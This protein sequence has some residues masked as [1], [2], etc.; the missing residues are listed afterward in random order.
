VLSGPIVIVD[1]HRMLAQSLGYALSAHGVSV[2][3]PALAEQAR[4]LGDIERLAPC[5]VLLDLDLGDAVGDGAGL[6]G[7][8]AAAGMR[9]LILSGTTQRTRF[10]AA[11]EAGAV[12]YV[13]KGCAFDVLLDTVL[14]AARG[15]DVLPAAD[16]HELATTL[17]T[18]RRAERR[19]LA[20][21]ERLT[22]REAEVLVELAAGNCVA[23][24]AEQSFVSVPTVRTQVRQV[25]AKLDVSS[26]LEAV[27]LAR[28]SGWLDRQPQTV[29]VS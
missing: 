20:P 16:R 29:A 2:E 24:I 10:A 25:L 9:V 27:A 18:Q 5:L 17:R 19:R 3:I 7:R 12:G 11:V 14:R 26:Q 8:L 23:Q 13:E 28:R 4:L 1:D 22:G 15:E 6:V 21:F